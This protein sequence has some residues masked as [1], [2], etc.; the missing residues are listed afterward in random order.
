MAPPSRHGPRGSLFQQ[1]YVE[2]DCKSV[3]EDT[4]ALVRYYVNELKLAFA[5]DR[6]IRKNG[7]VEGVITIE[8]TLRDSGDRTLDLA[9]RVK[10]KRPG[11]RG[12]RTA[13]HVTNDG[14]VLVPA[15]GTGPEQMTLPAAR[16][17]PDALQGEGAE[18]SGE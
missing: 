9:E 2:Y 7:V 17:V 15:P 18:A 1:A 5:D 14:R 3:A 11:M 4:N 8:I 6:V 13:A 10:C 16:P 12:A